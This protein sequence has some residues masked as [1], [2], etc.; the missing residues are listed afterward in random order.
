MYH[1]YWHVYTGFTERWEAYNFLIIFLHTVA[2]DLFSCF[3][4][5]LRRIQTEVGSKITRVV[6]I[7]V[8]ESL[9]AELSR[10]VD[11]L[12]CN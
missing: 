6:K 12:S 11:H 8:I 5:Q 1:M 7:G 3:N 10:V 9:H 4:V 2:V